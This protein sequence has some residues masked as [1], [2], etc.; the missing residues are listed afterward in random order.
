MSSLAERA[1]TF[2][3]G[4]RCGLRAHLWKEIRAR[5]RSRRFTA[6]LTAFLL[7]LA[8][9]VAG[10]LAIARRTVL[11]GSPWLGLQLFSI[12]AF[13]AVLLLAFI[14]IAV[15]AGSISGERERRTFDLLFV[16]R[17]S[18]LGLL[19]GKLAGSLVYVLLLLVASLPAFSLVYLF[20]GV[21][22]EYFLLFFIVACATAV[23]HASLGLLLSAWVRRTIPATILSFVIALGLMVGPPVAAGIAGA[24][25]AQSAS[26]SMGGVMLSPGYP[27]AWR[28]SL[29]VLAMLSFASEGANQ[30]PRTYA[31]ASPLLPLVSVLPVGGS[32]TSEMFV[33]VQT[34]VGGTLRAGDSGAA[35]LRAVYISGVDPVT[36]RPE[37]ARTW[38][39][40]V[41]YVAWSMIAA[42]LA[43][44]LAA[45][46]LTP[47]RVQRRARR[48]RVEQMAST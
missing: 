5:S 37:F 23:W 4:L 6:M 28:N 25:A 39:P 3:E 15:T 8:A 48:R 22:A 1:R 34:F 21:P 11:G 20:G 46:P 12:L 43:L 14:T 32:A 35:L 9:F 31:Y 41:Y 42:P 18:A 19:V 26:M 29:P 40:W 38:A 45:V 10:Y 13:T 36:G 33:G 30:K 24:Q 7:A 17:A 2:A 47:R 16:T 44:I 27:T